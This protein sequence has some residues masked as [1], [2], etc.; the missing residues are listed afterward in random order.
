LIFSIFLTGLVSKK[1]EMDRDAHPGDFMPF[2]ISTAKNRGRDGKV[3][4]KISTFSG[5]I[6]FFRDIF[7]MIERVSVN[8]I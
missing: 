8:I 2:S 7:R 4:E 1:V 6:F 5:S 3:I